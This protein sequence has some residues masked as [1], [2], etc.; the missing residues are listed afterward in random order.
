[1]RASSLIVDAFHGQL[2]VVVGEAAD[3]SKLLTA[4]SSFSIL[5]G[6]DENYADI[7]HLE[8]LNKIKQ[9]TTR[10]LDSFQGSK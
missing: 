3:Q 6:K 5:L 10:N 7:M 4:T 9:H 1:M 2:S 8:D